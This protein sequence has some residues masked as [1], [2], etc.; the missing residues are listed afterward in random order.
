MLID[1][2]IGSTFP[3]TEGDLMRR[4]KAIAIEPDDINIVLLTHAHGDHCG[5]NVDTEGKVVFKKAR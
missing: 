2:G 5:G 1:T 3:P 4:L